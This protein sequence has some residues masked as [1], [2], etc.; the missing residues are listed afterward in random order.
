MSHQDSLPAT[1]NQDWLCFLQG[2]LSQLTPAGHTQLSTWPQGASDSAISG[3]VVSSQVTPNAHWTVSTSKASALKLGDK[4]TRNVW[5]LQD[6]MEAI[7]LKEPDRTCEF[8]GTW[9]PSNQ[10]KQWVRGEVNKK[11]K[12]NL[13]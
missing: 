4:F 11:E 13:Q 7:G 3:W 5:E 9:S 6:T 8:I 12:E 1:D 2:W 10:G